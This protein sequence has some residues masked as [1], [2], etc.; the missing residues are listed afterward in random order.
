MSLLSTSKNRPITST[1]KTFLTL[2]EKVYHR[3]LNYQLFQNE[4]VRFLMTLQPWQQMKNSLS[5]MTKRMLRRTKTQLNASMERKVSFNLCTTCFPFWKS[6]TNNRSI[7][8]SPSENLCLS[9]VRTWLLSRGIKTHFSFQGSRRK[10][11]ISLWS[12]HLLSVENHGSIR[13]L[14]VVWVLTTETSQW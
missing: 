13:A 11:R 10:I 5:L 14:L 1:S 2:C 3:R 7:S 9:T 6:K 4:I 8:T 12:L